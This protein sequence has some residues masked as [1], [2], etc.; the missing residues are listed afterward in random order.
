MVISNIFLIFVLQIIN[1]KIMPSDIKVSFEVK[2]L[3][4]PIGKIY[5]LHV[6]LPD[7]TKN[8]GKWVDDH[9]DKIKEELKSVCHVHSV[10]HKST[11]WTNVRTDE[12]DYGDIILDSAVD[13]TLA[14]KSK[15]KKKKKEPKPVTDIRKIDLPNIDKED[16]VKLKN[17]IETEFFKRD[18]ELSDALYDFYMANVDLVSVDQ[19]KEICKEHG[20]DDLFLLRKREIRKIVEEKIQTT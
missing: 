4:F 20:T 5:K 15:K 11:M 3:G 9:A 10:Q 14:D 17:E 6:W 16:L 8:P 1:K 18:N 2:G 19:A 12:E 13:A 7:G